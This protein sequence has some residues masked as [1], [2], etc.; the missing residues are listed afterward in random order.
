MGGGELPG[1]GSAG[2]GHACLPRALAVR[3]IHHDPA[4]SSD[5]GLLAQR[6]RRRDACVETLVQQARA[7]VMSGSHGHVF[8]E[9]C[10]ASD[11]E[12]A[13]AVVEHS[14]ATSSEDLQLTST[15]RALHRL[16]MICKAY[17]VVVDIWVSIPTTAAVDD[18]RQT[19]WMGF[20]VVEWE[21][22]RGIF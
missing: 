5:G 7:P 2:D 14:V 19:C 15:R 17:D 6:A 12:L 20:E 11:S 4:V 8:L 10:C 9:L 1:A 3:V 16:L 13:A 22:K 18:L 21:L